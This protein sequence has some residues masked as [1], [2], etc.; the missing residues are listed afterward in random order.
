MWPQSQG[1]GDPWILSK[2]VEAQSPAEEFPGLRY[3]VGER[4]MWK[5]VQAIN[6]GGTI[7]KT[8]RH[9]FLE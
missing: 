4:G 9:R 6:L 2:T 3:K 1:E 5:R 7:V 8:V